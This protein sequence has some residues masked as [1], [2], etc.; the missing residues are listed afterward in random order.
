L[1]MIGEF[2]EGDSLKVTGFNSSKCQRCWNHFGIDDL[3][4][5]LCSRCQNYFK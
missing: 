4:N 1:L 2:H 3:K 5:E